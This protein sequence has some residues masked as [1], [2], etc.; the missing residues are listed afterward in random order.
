MKKKNMTYIEL[1]EYKL[2]KAKIYQ[3][4]LSQNFIIKKKKKSKAL[5]D[6][7]KELVEF[8]K[9]QLRILEVEQAP[10]NAKTAKLEKI[11]KLTKE[12]P[13]VNNKD[14]FLKSLK[15]VDLGS[16]G[17]ETGQEAQITTNKSI[18]LE[19]S[20][21]HNAFVDNSKVLVEDCFINS[22]GEYYVQVV[23]GRNRALIDLN[24]L[25]LL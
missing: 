12:E 11:G 21:M 5:D 17:L 23:N 3:K 9:N 6:V 13:V 18:I 15:A 4:L 2:E 14:D 16:C 8:V 20:S 25:K 10:S 1:L 24:D 22:Y 7:N 19:N